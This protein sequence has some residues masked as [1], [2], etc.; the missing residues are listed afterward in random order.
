MPKDNKTQ[1]F[2]VKIKDHKQNTTH[3]VTA[4]ADNQAEANY[5]ALKQ[6]RKMLGYPQNSNDLE[7]KT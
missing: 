4:Y 5:R 3:Y 1:F 6:V 7:V 2:A